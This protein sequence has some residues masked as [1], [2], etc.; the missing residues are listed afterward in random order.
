MGIQIPISGLVTIPNR[1]ISNVRLGACGQSASTLVPSTGGHAKPSSTVVN[2]YTNSTGVCQ[3]WVYSKIRFIE[4]MLLFLWS[5]LLSLLSLLLD[6]VIYVWKMW[7]ES[8]LILF[9]VKTSPEY[10][11]NRLS[12]YI[13]LKMKTGRCRCPGLAR[14]CATC[15]FRWIPL[16]LVVVRRF[17]WLSAAVLFLFVCWPFWGKSFD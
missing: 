10:V 17:N 14:L 1:G 2:W 3:T 11:V 13:W 16:V 5:S 12:C 4:V 7:D 15:L 6:L 8:H 9:V